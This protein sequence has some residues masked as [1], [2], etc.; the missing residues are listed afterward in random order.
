MITCRK[1]L[2]NN[3]LRNHPLFQ[4]ATLKGRTVFGGVHEGS[5]GKYNWKLKDKKYPEMSLIS[6]NYS[7]CELP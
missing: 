4:D 5:I 6:L 1:I 7:K 2:P 3:G